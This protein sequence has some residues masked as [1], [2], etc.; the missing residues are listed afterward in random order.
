M[1]LISIATLSSLSREE[2][3]A[4]IV[5]QQE[6]IGRLEERV[7]ELE[8]ERASA[9]SPKGMPGNKIEPKRQ[10][11]AEQVRK[12]RARNYAR[13]RSAEPNERVEHAYDHCPGCGTGLV[14]GSVKFSREVIEVHPSPVVVTEHVY[15]ERCCPYCNKG[16][17]PPVE[18]DGV[19]TV[20]RSRLGIR[21]T[22]LI[23]CLR[24]EA[25]LPIATILW[26][27]STFHALKLSQG[28]VVKMLGR[29]ARRGTAQVEEIL[30]RIRGAPYVHAD[31][32]GWR[33]DG[34]NGYVWTYSTPTERYFTRGGRDGG[35]VN[36]VL[37]PEFSGVLVSDFYVG[38]NVYLG[39]HQ[40]CWAHLLRDIH[41]LGEKH[42]ADEG[43]AE[44]AGKVRRVYERAKEWVAQHTELHEG[45]HWQTTYQAA[46]LLEGHLLDVCR[47]YLPA[48]GE[49]QDGGEAG[50]A[51]RGLCQRIE[52]YIKELFV[53]VA[54]PGVP[55][56]NNPA[57]RS[58]RHLVVTRKISGG[59][60]SEVGTDT[61]MT[62][63]TLC[64]TWRARGL[65]PYHACLDLLSSPLL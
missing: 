48:E 19:E 45:Q 36:R 61:K 23:V 26:Y 28:A 2:L 9:E 27:L 64:G 5:Q 53:F 33:Q 8:S 49:G 41:E 24:E 10:P 35:V 15:L 14:G 4:I 56:E 13:R 38:Y 32:T 58:L 63:A 55:S 47:P 40:R 50:P 25:R 52:R 44:W 31:E 43:M 20:G 6:V 39:E 21:L 65:N 1:E 62:L 59:T 29:V 34:E 46:R 7:G 3:I 11:K 18:L 51:Q 42:P 30:E 12:R 57:E 60:R 54:H 16:Y 37:G 17:T 22:A